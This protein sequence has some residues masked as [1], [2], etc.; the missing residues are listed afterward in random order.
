MRL[1]ST[2]APESYLTVNS[3]SQRADKLDLDSIRDLVE[4]RLA[5]LGRS[6]A[7][8]LEDYPLAR[9]SGW[10]APP[11]GHSRWRPESSSRRHFGSAH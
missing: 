11:A 9:L 6:R 7:A 4:Q 5:G 8:R 2:K 10:T 1:C 3:R